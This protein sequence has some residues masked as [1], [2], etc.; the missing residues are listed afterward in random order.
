M[1]EMSLAS[2]AIPPGL[3]LTTTLKVMSLP[4][5]ARPLS[6]HRPSRVVSI[7]PPHRGKTTLIKKQILMTSLIL[8]FHANFLPLSSGS[9]PAMTAASPVAPA[10]STTAFSSSISLK[11]E[12]YTVFVF[13]SFS[14]LRMAMEIHA[15]LTV[16]ILSI[17]GP[18][19]ARALQPTVGTVKPAESKKVSL[20]FKNLSADHLPG[21][22]QCGSALVCQP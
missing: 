21:W 10:P 7:L 19:V 4:S 2:S 13:F 15:S 1:D 6:R 12:L 18:P 11:V 16:T 3:S 14:N 17:R 22:R 8:N 9:I 20:V 5:A